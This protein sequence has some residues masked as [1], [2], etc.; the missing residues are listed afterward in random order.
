MPRKLVQDG[1]RG[2]YGFESRYDTAIRNS[3]SKL[4]NQ[5]ARLGLVKVRHK[6]TMKEL[7]EQE[8]AYDI[9][10]KRE[11]R[12]T[13]MELVEMRA[14]RRVYRQ[15]SFTAF[16]KSE[17]KRLEKQKQEQKE[18]EKRKKDQAERGR[19]NRDDTKKI[20]ELAS[21]IGK[22]SKDA[23]RL[24]QPETRRKNSLNDDKGDKGQKQRGKDKIKIRHSIKLQ[25]LSE[26]NEKKITL[27]SHKTDL[28]PLEKEML[29]Q[30]SEIT[31][32]TN[33]PEIEINGHLESNPKPSD[34]TS[35]TKRLPSSGYG[36]LSKLFMTQPIPEEDEEYLSHTDSEV[37]SN[38]TSQS[39]ESMPHSD[40]SCT[41]DD[42][43][44]TQTPNVLDVDDFSEYDLQHKRNSVATGNAWKLGLFRSYTFHNRKDSVAASSSFSKRTST[45]ACE[46]VNNN[47]PK[48]WELPL[49]REDRK[50]KVF[51]TNC[52]NAFKLRRMID[53]KAVQLMQDW[54]PE[55]VRKM[56]AK[57]ILEQMSLPDLVQRQKPTSAIF[58][59]FKHNKELH[60]SLDQ[61]QHVIKRPG[62]MA[63]TDVLKIN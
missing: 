29:T 25:S 10:Q 8:K 48:L 27:H 55:N 39:T 59:D 47:R 45:A 46:P 16:T 2:W 5:N 49:T 21:F 37:F 17:E 35:K 42:I 63:R 7:E 50:S 36:T 15:Y 14:Y 19:E 51:P 44:D 13:Q 58:R 32:N 61:Y 23:G 56:K 60:G 43:F 31:N 26:V 30:R 11:K 53:D 9:K 54:S 57:K 34:D 62:L 4:W 40:S 12:N 28:G 33:S 6:K 20:T 18:E 52:R 1:Y 3:L 22:R 38:F 41:K 24:Y